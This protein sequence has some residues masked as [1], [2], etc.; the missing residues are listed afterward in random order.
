[1][2]SSIASNCNRGRIWHRQSKLNDLAGDRRALVAVGLG[3]VWLGRGI[4]RSRCGRA[5]RLSAASVQLTDVDELPTTWFGYEAV[6]VL[7]LSIGDGALCRELA[8]D[9][10]RLDGAAALGRVGR[11]AG[12]PVRRRRGRGIV[13]RRRSRWPSWCRANSP[14][15]CGLPQTRSARAFCR[16]GGAIAGQGGAGRTACAASSST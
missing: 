9:A 1:M 5:A 11:P 15:W 10:A 6:D 14:T 8:A 3:A 12:D 7:V 2:R 4:C 13:G 16:V